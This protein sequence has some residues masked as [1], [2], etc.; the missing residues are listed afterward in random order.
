MPLAFI[1]KRFNYPFYIKIMNRPRLYLTLIILFSLLF[2][3]LIAAGSH[4][5]SINNKLLAIA[6]FLFAFASAIG[7]MVSLA[8]FIRNKAIQQ[9]KK[10]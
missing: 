6:L 10:G 5:L 7:Q 2:M 1:S 4:L 3:A 8:L 9:N